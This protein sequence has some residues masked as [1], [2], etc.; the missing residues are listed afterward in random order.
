MELS[1]LFFFVVV[2]TFFFNFFRDRHLHEITFIDNIDVL[3][4][5]NFGNYVTSTFDKNIKF[6]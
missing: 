3:N 1:K 2:T 6:F 5:A 4:C